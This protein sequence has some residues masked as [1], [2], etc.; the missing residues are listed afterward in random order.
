MIDIHKKLSTGVPVDQQIV[1]SFGNKKAFG[2]K[3]S[4]VKYSTEIPTLR[5]IWKKSMRLRKPLYV[6]HVVRSFY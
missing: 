2:K 5:G 6:I 3:S 4:V 1:S